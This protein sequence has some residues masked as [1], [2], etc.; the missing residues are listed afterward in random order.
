MIRRPPRSTLFP[1]T[2]LFRSMYHKMRI[3]GALIGVES[4]SEEGL[5]SANK[6]WN[7]TGKKMVETIQKIQEA[8]IMVLSSIIFGLESDT[9]QT[10]RTMRQFAL[11]SGSVLAQFPFYHPYPGTKDFYEMMT[12]KKNLASPNFVPKHKIR[13]S[14]RSEEHTSELQSLA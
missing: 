6:Q 5:K 13:I 1:Y 2:T 7:P 8:G 12:D 11:E 14:G 9:L 3:R 4:F 10:I